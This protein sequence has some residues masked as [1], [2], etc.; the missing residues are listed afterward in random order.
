MSS[1]SYGCSHVRLDAAIPLWARISVFDDPSRRHPFIFP[2]FAP[3]L[4][5]HVETSCVH[6]L[7]RELLQIATEQSSM[8]LSVRLNAHPMLVQSPS[9]SAA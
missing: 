8:T 3:G 4:K 2:Y 5:K 7:A 6:L 1:K 9:T